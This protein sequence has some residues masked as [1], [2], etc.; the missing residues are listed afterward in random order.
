MLRDHLGMRSRVA[1]AAACGLA[2]VACGSAEPAAQRAPAETAR[3]AVTPMASPE[4][5]DSTTTIRSTVAATV[6]AANSAA[7]RPAYIA[8]G[9]VFSIAVLPDGFVAR[10]PPTT[11]AE[12]LSPDGNR[13]VSQT[14]I[15][16]DLGQL[17]IVTLT[18]GV[19]AEQQ[20]SY[21]AAGPVV[22]GVLD[23]RIVYALADAMTGQRGMAWA[24]GPADV[25]WLYGTGMT[26]EQLAPIANA[27]EV[28]I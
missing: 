25:V 22:V 16:S 3:P 21:V 4:Q 20:L 28:T 23:D 9:E 17:L 13:V 1:S 7:P 19:P 2:L 10:Q 27:I 12:K 11:V 18:S 6:A 24:A 8:P 5:A 14:F 15:N 26:D